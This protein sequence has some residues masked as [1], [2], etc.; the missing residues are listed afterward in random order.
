MSMRA[1]LSRCTFLPA[2]VITETWVLL[3]A[4]ELRLR[5]LRPNTP[6][7]FDVSWPAA[8]RPPT[9]PCDVP[10]T[11]VVELAVEFTAPAPA[12]PTVSAVLVSVPT[13]LPAGGGSPGPPPPPGAPG[14]TPTISPPPPPPSRGA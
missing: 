3:V 10:A 14:G 13:V 9:A 2:E 7:L 8:F 1:P 6:R 5:P 12:A 11:P 4:T